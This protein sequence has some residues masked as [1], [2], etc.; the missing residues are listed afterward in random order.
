[1]YINNNSTKHRNSCGF[2]DSSSLSGSTQSKLSHDFLISAI[3]SMKNSIKDIE[4]FNQED[5][6]WSEGEFFS[7]IAIRSPHQGLIKQSAKMCV[8]SY[9]N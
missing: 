9:S 8:I 1:M 4:D 6:N 3:S 7:L 2:S 5:Y